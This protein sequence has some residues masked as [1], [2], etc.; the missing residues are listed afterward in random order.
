MIDLPGLWHGEDGTV[1]VLAV[2]HHV[3]TGEVSSGSTASAWRAAPADNEAGVI[4]HFVSAC[5]FQ[6]KRDWSQEGKADLGYG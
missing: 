3:L 1:H 4:A 2:R 6:V 5:A